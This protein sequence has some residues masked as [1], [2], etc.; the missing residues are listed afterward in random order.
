MGDC[1][2]S[3]IPLGPR[4]LRLL[5]KTESAKSLVVLGPSIVAPRKGLLEGYLSRNGVYVGGLSL[6]AA[7]LDVPPKELQNKTFIIP[8]SS[9]VESCHPDWDDR[10]WGQNREYTRGR[11]LQIATDAGCS[12]TDRMSYRQLKEFLPV[13]RKE[14]SEKC[15]LVQGYVKSMFQENGQV[16][17]TM[18]DGEKQIVK[19]DFIVNGANTHVSST[20][21]EELGVKVQGFGRVY[22]LPKLE[23]HVAV[24][25]DGMGQNSVWA[26]RDF[27]GLRPLVVFYSAS[28]QWRSELYEQMRSLNQGLGAQHKAQ[29]RMFCIEDCEIEVESSGFVNVYGKDALSGQDQ[30]ATIPLG[31][32]YS[33]RGSQL[34]TDLVKGGNFYNLEAAKYKPP[35]KITPA[36]SLRGRV[37]TY[38]KETDDSLHHTPILPPGNLSQRT[39]DW[40]VI[41][42]GHISKDLRAINSFKPWKNAVMEAATRLNLQ[43][44]QDFFPCAQIAFNYTHQTHVP[45]EEHL[46]KAVENITKG[47]ITEQDGTVVPYADFCKRYKNL[48]EKSPA[49]QKDDAPTH[50]PPACSGPG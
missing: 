19:G 41:L 45:S 3:K 6:L 11:L 14:L 23:S 5:E 9:F 28:D 34:N 2:F 50:L 37:V 31:M 49:A 15:H 26:V 16:H 7:A 25:L 21:F 39:T 27:G 13:A 1:M 46:A 20:F 48:L 42:G 30:T 24:A 35:K 4:C 8:K 44:N 29:C 12:R 43:V 36:A 38:Y 18:A 22:G 47:S 32:F 10:L 17:F 33:A 40:T